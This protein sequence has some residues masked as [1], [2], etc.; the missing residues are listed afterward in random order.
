MAPA[1]GLW[2]RETSWK[3]MKINHKHTISEKV[4]HLMCYQIDDVKLRF[5]R[6]RFAPSRRLMMALIRL[7]IP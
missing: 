3:Y 7:K 5:C 6:P 2:A 4:C 1:V